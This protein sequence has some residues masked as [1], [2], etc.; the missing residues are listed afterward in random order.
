M[1]DVMNAFICD[2][3][4]LRIWGAGWCE[5]LGDY[6]L[7]AIRD[8]AKWAVAGREKLPSVSAFIDDVTGDGRECAGT[9]SAASTTG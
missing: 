6:P 5:A 2:N 1:F 7:I 9:L 3:T 8:A 4:K